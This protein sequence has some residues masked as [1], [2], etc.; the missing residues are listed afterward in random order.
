[1]KKYKDYLIEKEQEMLKEKEVFP[2]TDN[3]E[4]NEL[5]QLVEDMTKWMS[6]GSFKQK[7]PA[8]MIAEFKTTMSKANVVKRCNAA[9]RRL[10]ASEQ[11]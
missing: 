11:E 5:R 4:I 8:S 10:R 1:M 7:T 3:T 2:Y 9:E 6:I